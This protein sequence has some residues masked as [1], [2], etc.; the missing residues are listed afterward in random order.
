MDEDVDESIGEMGQSRCAPVGAS[1][2]LCCCT[3]G[4]SRFESVLKLDAVGKHG[5]DDG[6]SK[7][8]LNLIPIIQLIFLNQHK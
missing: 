7:N 5:S 3:V 1:V 2:S 4:F 6:G 8:D